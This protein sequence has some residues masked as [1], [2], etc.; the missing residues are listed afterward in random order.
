MMQMP[1]FEHHKKFKTPKLSVEDMAFS[2]ILP[3]VRMNWP[4]YAI[5]KHHIA[6]AKALEAVERG[7]ITRLIIT[8][9]PRSGKTMLVSQYFPAWYLGRNPDE[10]IIYATYSF[11]RANDVG[12]EVRNLFLSPVH[13]RVFTGCKISTDSKGANKFSLDQGG[14]YFAVGV[15]SA[16]TGRGANVFIMD[17]LIKGQEDAD[18]AISRQAMINWFN[19]VAYTRLMPK[20]AIILIMTRW[21]FDDIAGYLID[22]TAHEGWHIINFPAIA[23]EDNDAIGRMRGDALW[24]DKFPLERLYQIKKTV[25]S[26]VWNALYMGKPLPD[27]GGMINLNW[28]NERYT[29]QNLDQLIINTR[30]LSEDNKNKNTVEYIKQVVISA[31]TAFKE[32]QLNDPSA[33]TVWFVS[34]HNKFYLADVV[35]KK[36]EYPDLKRTAIG[37]YEKYA[38][39]I[40]GIK[41]VMIIEDKASGQSLI[42]DLKRAT[43]I[44]VVKISPDKD[45]QVR[46][47]QQTQYLESGRVIFPQNAHWLH[48]VEL[49][50]AQ[51]PFSKHDDICDSISQ[52][53]KWLTKP[54]YLSSRQK[55]HWK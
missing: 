1:T 26:R 24:P 10:Q 44:P 49:Q 19:S 29:K 9:P 22:E 53:L 3:Y 41:P 15:G 8:M 7:E 27:E 38:R 42:Q 17:D 11:E 18:S 51:F 54:K 28:F 43:T 14:N 23:D 36:L 37:L 48:D 25:G 40:P 45:K 31:D 32:Q 30:I 21:R 5:A 2:R 16:V 4:G 39:I 13:N 35:N 34:S 52:F 55:L 20:N 12:R 50:L 33:F 47:S 46:M 6:I